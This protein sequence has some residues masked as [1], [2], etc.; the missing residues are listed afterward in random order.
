M[1]RRGPEWVPRFPS[2]SAGLCGSPTSRYS[3]VV[4]TCIPHRWL[5]VN[6]WAV[7]TEPYSTFVGLRVM[8]RSSHFHA[9]DEERGGLDGRVTSG[10]HSCVLIMLMLMWVKSHLTKGIRKSNSA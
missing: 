3:S 5:N 1:T 4:G 8:L 2:N 9:S 10:I 7:R 6:C